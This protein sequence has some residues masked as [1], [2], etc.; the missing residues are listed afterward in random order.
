MRQRTQHR[1]P[2]TI[3]TR[4]RTADFVI[5]FGG[6]VSIPTNNGGSRLTLFVTTVDDQRIVIEYNAECTVSAAT[7]TT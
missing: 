3:A 1:S 7:T 4:Y 2:E 6:P 5:A